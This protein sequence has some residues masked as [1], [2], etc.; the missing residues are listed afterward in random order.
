MVLKVSCPT[1]HV[2]DAAR[3]HGPSTKKRSR[4]D[5]GWNE[6]ATSYQVGGGG[7][8]SSSSSSSSQRG[9]FS[10]SSSSGQEKDV[11]LKAL[12]S[13]VKD[14][15]A[16]AFTG[17]KKKQHKEDK[18]TKL[19]AAPVKQQQMPFKMKMG[20]LAGRKKRDETTEKSAQE[21]GVVLARVAS[22]K[23]GGGQRNRTSSSSFQKK[24]PRR[25]GDSASIDINTKGG[26]L[27]LSK[28]RLPGRLTKSFRR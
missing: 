23:V 25:S 7:G 4:G 9:R 22:Q 18:L 12:F 19:G 13:T 3:H 27:H 16:T 8:S 17:M 1:V 6:D 24:K 10:G 26:V 21:S 15:S 5:M 20:I 14:F 2:P 11:D 28:K